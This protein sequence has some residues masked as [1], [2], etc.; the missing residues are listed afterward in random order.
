MTAEPTQLERLLSRYLDHEC[1]AE[2]RELVDTLVARDAD[3]RALLDEYRTLDPLVSAALQW[4]LRPSP[5]A[6]T[7]SPWLRWSRRALAV[8]AA[9][10]LAWLSWQPWA[11]HTTPVP[12]TARA[13]HTSWFAP[14][15]PPADTVQPV[16]S[17]YERP[18]V[19]LQGTERN[20]I[21]IP[22]DEP[23]AYFIVQVDRIRT[24]VLPVHEDY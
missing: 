9:A 16:P 11:A 3:A 8:A 4:E 14:T 6:A 13:T 5:A 1:S 2:E 23:G 7:T 18:E 21:V 19:R 15:S 24:H 12:G 10:C 17:A 20:W 22:G